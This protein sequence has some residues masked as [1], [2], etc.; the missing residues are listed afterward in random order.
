VQSV[1]ADS[2]MLAASQGRTVPPF[3][4]KKKVS[5]KLQIG[6][7]KLADCDTLPMRLGA[8]MEMLV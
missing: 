8:K 5:K 4:A 2:I 6:D 1:G 7:Q 3:A